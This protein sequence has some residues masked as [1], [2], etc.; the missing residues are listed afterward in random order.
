[1]RRCEKCRV[2][3]TGHPVQCPLCGSETAP[4]GEVAGKTAGNNPPG[5]GG[6]AENLRSVTNAADPAA[7]DRE[8]AG[9]D[10]R[11]YPYLPYAVPPHLKLIRLLQLG[12]IAAAAICVVINYAL[13]SRGWWSL[14]VIAGTASFWLTFAIAMYKRH[15]IPKNLVWQTALISLLALG[16]DIFTGFRGWSVDYVIPVLCIGTMA[17]LAVWARIKK[18]RTEDYLIYLILDSIFGILPA[19]LLLLGIPHVNFPSTICI[20]VSIVSLSSLWLLEGNALW[21]EICR[22]LHI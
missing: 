3:L 13:P 15:N 21:A 17:C 22:R 19:L 18:L 5:P 1:M 7:G 4:P 9:G 12:T 14:F 16:W 20:A 10:G 8:S 2:N 6:A 11:S